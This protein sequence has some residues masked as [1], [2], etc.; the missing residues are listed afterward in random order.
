MLAESTHRKN[1][2]IYTKQGTGPSRCIAG[3]LSARHCTGSKDHAVVCKHFKLDSVCRV[4][5]ACQNH[6]V[7]HVLGAVESHCAGTLGLGPT[8]DNTPQEV[9][10]DCNH[11]PAATPC[12]QRP[13][14]TQGL[15]KAAPVMVSK[16]I[17][18]SA[19]RGRPR[20]LH[21][22]EGSPQFPPGT[23]RMANTAWNLHG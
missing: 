11:V 4:P 7:P 21:Q 8:L 3:S 16:P 1:G 12:P 20:C 2:T 6:Q 23:G 13:A 9:A 22:R 14:S 19:R 15:D 18:P 10:G 17:Q 5:Q